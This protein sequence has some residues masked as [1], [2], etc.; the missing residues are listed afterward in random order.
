MAKYFIDENSLPLLVFSRIANFTELMD[1]GT[2]EIDFK[3]FK[4]MSSK[5]EASINI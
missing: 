5:Q 2:L 4:L 3:N 1:G